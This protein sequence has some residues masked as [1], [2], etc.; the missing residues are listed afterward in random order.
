MKQIRVTVTRLAT[1][2]PDGPQAIF[3]L[4]DEVRPDDM[5]L[6][7]RHWRRLTADPEIQLFLRGFGPDCRTFTV[8]VPP[9]PDPFAGPPFTKRRGA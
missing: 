3:D 2:G 4:G 5:P 7:R 6:I 8:T 9:V 1:A